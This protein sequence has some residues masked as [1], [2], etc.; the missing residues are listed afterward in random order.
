MQMLQIFFKIIKNV[1]L[2][3]SSISIKKG[4]ENE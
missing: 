2:L 3:H 4:T 1:W